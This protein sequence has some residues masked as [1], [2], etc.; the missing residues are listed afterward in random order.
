M[1]FSV[2]RAPGPGCAILLTVCFWLSMDEWLS[3]S[4]LCIIFTRLKI[5]RTAEKRH[6]TNKEICL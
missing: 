4:A 3:G 1:Q 2:V 5:R 6:Y